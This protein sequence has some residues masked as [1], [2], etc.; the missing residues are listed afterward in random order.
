VSTKVTISTSRRMSLIEDRSS[1]GKLERPTPK[2][3]V[4]TFAATSLYGDDVRKIA[5]EEESNGIHTHFVAHR[6]KGADPLAT[7]KTPDAGYFLLLVDADQLATPAKP[8][9]LNLVIDHSGSMGGQKIVQARLAAL[10]MLDNLRPADFFNIHTF[11]GTVSSWAVSPQPANASNVANARALIQS[12]SATGST[13]LNSA[14]IAGLGGKINCSG[15]DRFDA[16]ILFSDGQATAGELNRQK[17]YENALSYNCQE[18]RIFTFAVGTG[19]D[20]TL[21]EGIARAARGKNFILNNTQAATDLAAT[22]RTLFEDISSVRL[23]NLTLKIEGVGALDV[24]P[25]KPR[26]LF[27]GGQVLLVGRYATPGAATLT[28]TADA[29]GAPFSRVLNVTAP[30]TR[31]EDDFVK[32]IWASEKVGSLLGKMAYAKDTA[33]LKK[34]ITD[35]GLAYRM[36]TPFTSFVAPSSPRQTPNYAGGSGGS[37]G[38]NSSGSSGGG[39]WG[40]GSVE[41]FYLLVLVLLLPLLWRRRR[42]S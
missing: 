14:I 2:D 3:A 21:L 19:A 42:T 17:I 36:Q 4:L 15:D 26:D 30:A 8:R 1:K 27:N 29:D 13:D 25:E 37:S 18:A 28:L 40:A 12:L 41:P 35:L 16:M 7:S 33:S 20:V 11:S 6:A 34:E 38:G 23:T 32:Y 39:G 10:A 24:L 31:A 5:Y 22:A 9:T